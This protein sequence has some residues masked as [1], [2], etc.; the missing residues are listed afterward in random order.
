M[1]TGETSTETEITTTDPG[2]TLLER[3]VVYKAELDSILSADQHE[4]VSLLNEDG[5]ARARKNTSEPAYD[6]DAMKTR[7]EFLLIYDQQHDNANEVYLDEYLMQYKDLLDQTVLQ[8]QAG[9]IDAVEAD[10]TVDF[11]DNLGMDALVTMSVD[12]GIVVKITL[13]MDGMSFYY[14]VK[15]GYESDCFYIRE[16]SQVDPSDFFEY[17]EFWDQHSM[18]NV[19]YGERDFWYQYVNQTDNTLFSISDSPDQFILRW[20]NPETGVRTTL[21][22]G[23][24][25]MDYFEL[26][27]ERGVVFSYQNNIS[28]GTVYVA[29]QMLEATGWDAAY[30]TDSDS[31]YAGIYRDGAKVFDEVWQYN[32]SLD[33]IFAN[34]R[35][36]ISMTPEEFT[37]D[38][39]NLSRFGLDFQHPGLTV[40]S[41]SDLMDNA[42]EDSAELS[43][44]R[45]IDFS[46]EDLRGG[47]YSVIDPE[48]APEFFPMN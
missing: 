22:R 27:N 16:L 12:G 13:E 26:F 6:P 4:P 46:E 9:E 29:W 43:V 47:L 48:V 8:L 44:Y 2:K 10:L 39:L 32:V 24:E 30:V 1:S 41:I 3:A 19:R 15:L 11:R 42:I 45:G 40:Q 38:V 36:D 14:G 17:F 23:A 7:E 25:E 35:V 33:E 37:D 5:E 28:E 31:P 20:F 18:I 21:V 34:V